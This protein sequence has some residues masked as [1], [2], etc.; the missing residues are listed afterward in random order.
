MTAKFTASNG[1]EIEITE[2]G[3][4]RGNKHIH[5]GM[6][7]ATAG[8]EG[9]EALREYFQHERDQELNRWRDPDNPDFVVYRRPEEDDDDG[10]AVAVLDD[11]TGVAFTY[12]EK[13]GLDGQCTT[14]YENGQEAAGRYFAA[15]PEPKPWEEAKPREAWVLTIDGK[16]FPATA[17]LS[18]FS[19][20]CDFYTGGDCLN[21]HDPSITAGRRIWPEED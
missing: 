13:Y 11:S 17:T 5:P 3:Y 18:L 19:D 14:R 4:L 6:L 8:R 7:Y 9:V 21:A 2:D 12:W 10:R 20:G 16:E 15:H 1:V